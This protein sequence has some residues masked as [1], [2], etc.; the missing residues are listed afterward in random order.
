M[1]P[2]T[3]SPLTEYQSQ[4][5][6]LQNTVNELHEKARLNS[7]RTR[8]ATLEGKT[9]GMDARVKKMRTDGYPF[10]KNLAVDSSSLTSRWA[11]IKPDVELRLGRESASLQSALPGLEAKVS[12]MTAN[13][14]NLPYLQS[15]LPGV[16]A[17]TEAYGSR[18]DAAESSLDAVVDPISAEIDKYCAHLD[19]IEKMLKDLQTASFQLFTSEAGILAVKAVWVKGGD[20][21]KDDPEGLLFLTDQRLVFEQREEVATKKVLFITTERKTVQQ[22]GF[23]IHI[24]QV[25]E[26]VPSKQGVFKNEDNIRLNFAVGGFAPSA[27]LH[28]WKDASDWAAIFNQVQSGQFSANR[29]IPLDPSLAEKARLAPTECPKCGGKITTPV[30]RGQD[31]I[32]CSFCGSVIKL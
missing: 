10:E 23:E 7:F 32:T 26:V 3:T 11:K 9:Q 1:S 22:L 31:S 15:T 8:V 4:L 6:D 16:K 21:D 27:T 5:T 18:I 24:N 30:V 12:A 14:G 20:E 29:A 17:E 25:E 13:R 2:E 19:E 28:I